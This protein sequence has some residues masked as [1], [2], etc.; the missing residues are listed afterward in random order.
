MERK[1]TFLKFSKFLPDILATI[2]AFALLN[3]LLWKAILLDL[4]EY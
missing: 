3:M 1:T 4:L 2:A